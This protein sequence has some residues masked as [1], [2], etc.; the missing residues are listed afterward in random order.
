M[1]FDFYREN[2]ETSTE[3]EGDKLQKLSAFSK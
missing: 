3:H 1:W 2:K